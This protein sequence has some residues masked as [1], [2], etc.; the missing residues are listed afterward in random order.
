MSL[1]LRYE[2]SAFC[3]RERGAKT[4][5]RTSAVESRERIDPQKRRQNAHM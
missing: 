3:A 1:L 5:K 2:V 4:Q